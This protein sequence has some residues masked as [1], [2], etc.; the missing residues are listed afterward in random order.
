MTPRNG[1]DDECKKNI[2]GDFMKHKKVMIAVVISVF[3][4]ATDVN[5]CSIGNAYVT[6]LYQYTDGTTMFAVFDH[7]TDCWT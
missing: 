3:A 4:S 6:D 5:A 7:A 2:R 1:S